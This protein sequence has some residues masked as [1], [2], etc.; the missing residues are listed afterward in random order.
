MINSIS[1]EWAE[2][3]AYTETPT[4][5][6]K[7]KRDNTFLGR[8]TMDM[9][10]GNYGFARILT[11]IARG[12]LFHNPDGT[13]KDG[14]PYDRT[15]YAR[16]ALCAWCSISDKEKTTRK[17]WQIETDFKNLKNEFPELVDENGNGWYIRYLH[18]IVDFINN[19]RDKVGQSTYKI[20]DSINNIEETWRKKVMQYQIPIFSENTK[21]DKIIRFDDVIADALELGD[22]RCKPVILT[23]EQKNWLAKVT[24]KKVPVDVTE[25]L[26]EFYIANK[27]DDGEWCVLPITNIEAYLGSTSLSRLYMKRLNGTVLERKDSI[28]SAC[29]VKFN[30]I[31]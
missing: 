7:N 17:E 30:E 22:L 21:G 10:M 28:T 25:T 27:P 2:F 20:A 11:I 16:H 12:Y 19:N 13:I 29:V 8:F 14:D 4:Y 26:L 31:L 15:D 24:P 1:N 3:L 9:I 6:V 23:Q 18:G 5:S